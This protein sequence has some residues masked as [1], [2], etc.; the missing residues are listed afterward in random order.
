M[1]IV[2]RLRNPEKRRASHQQFKL[3]SIHAMI[4]LGMG[5]HKSLEKGN[6]SECMTEREK[7]LPRGDKQRLDVQV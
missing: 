7:S 5:C 1:S 2:L 4:Q 3:K 6:N